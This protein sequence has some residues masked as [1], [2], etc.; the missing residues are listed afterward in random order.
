MIDLTSKLGNIYG[1]KHNNGS[2]I[3]SQNQFYFYIVLCQAQV[4][5][6]NS[7]MGH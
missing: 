6:Y 7:D 3:Y 1:I 2:K 5:K 4:F